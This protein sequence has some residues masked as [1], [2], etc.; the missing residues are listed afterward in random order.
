MVGFLKGLVRRV[1]VFMW[2]R[3]R[4]CVVSVAL[5]CGVGCNPYFG[6]VRLS[7]FGVSAGMRRCSGARCDDLLS[8]VVLL[9]QVVVGAP[10]GQAGSVGAARGVLICG[11]VQVG[12]APLQGFVL[13]RA[14]QRA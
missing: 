12:A 13:R 6:C 14:I 3:W 1:I 5:V 4:A 11:C 8:W 7:A 10:P 2:L 9:V